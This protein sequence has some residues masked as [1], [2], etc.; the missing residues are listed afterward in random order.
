M[1]VS[2]VSIGTSVSPSLSIPR[3]PAALAA[4]ALS[5]LVSTLLVLGATTFNMGLC[6]ANT[7]VMAVSDMYVI[8]CE[9][10][11]LSLTFLAAHRSIGNTHLILL[12]FVAVWPMLLASVRFI[13]G[14]DSTIDVKIVRDLAIP[15][16]FFL[17]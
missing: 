6:F 13:T 4:P 5:P 2:P 10:V 12:G 14:N 8:L 17:L 11:I 1:S 9:A 3:V 15:I 7:N 16:G